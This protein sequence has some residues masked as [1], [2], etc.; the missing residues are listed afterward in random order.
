MSESEVDAYFQSFFDGFVFEIAVAAL[1]IYEH[2]LTIEGALRVFTGRGVIS[3]L[4]FALNWLSLL[5]FAVINILIVLPW[6]SPSTCASIQI[7]ENVTLLFMMAV[8]S[9]VIALRVYAVSGGK[10][11]LVGL[12]LAMSLVPICAS[13]YI[14]SETEYKFVM[15]FL[16]LDTCV[17]N[18]RYSQAM[19]KRAFIAIRVC[20]ALSDV[21]IISATWSGTSDSVHVSPE[22]ALTTR[23]TIADLFLRDG[24]LYFVTMSLMN[25]L[26]L[27]V[28]FTAASDERL[29][30]MTVFLYPVSAILVSRFLLNVRE[31]AY[32]T[33][34]T[35]GIG[36]HTELSS[37]AFARDHSDANMTGYSH[38]KISRNH[39]SNVD[40]ERQQWDDPIEECFDVRPERMT[41]E[42]ELESR[43]MT[44]GDADHC[45][46]HR[47]L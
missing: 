15:N 40:D 16:S 23:P 3:I 26:D 20:T 21:I 44:E 5:L 2:I 24:A 27:I 29:I 35:S 19:W 11:W 28:Y 34:F 7:A 30:N 25:V 4:L 36:G 8:P 12:T 17:V 9:V 10:W 18:P 33:D 42:I 14:Y 41:G 22:T 6:E 46:G 1:I 45:A 13:I 39:S 31:A 32:S 37:V 43:H 47:V 38:S